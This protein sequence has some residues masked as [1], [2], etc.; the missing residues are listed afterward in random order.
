MKIH[1]SEILNALMPVYG[2]CRGETAVAAYVTE[3]DGNSFVTLSPSTETYGLNRMYM[4]CRYRKQYSY[5]SPSDVEINEVERK[6]SAGD[7]SVQYIFLSK[8]QN[9]EIT[10]R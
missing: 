10:L 2:I 5:I 6:R 1:C 8:D 9:G 7:F 3:G 4:S